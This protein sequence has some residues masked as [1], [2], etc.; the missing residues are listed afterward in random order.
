MKNNTKVEPWH[1]LINSFPDKSKYLEIVAA[2]IN[3]FGDAG[4]GYSFADWGRIVRQQL[5]NPNEVEVQSETNN[6]ELSLEQR[7]LQYLKNNPFSKASKIASFLDINK[8]KVNSFLY[9]L[10]I[11]G[12]CAVDSDYKWHICEGNKESTIEESTAKE[13]VVEEP[14][15]VEYVVEEP[16]SIKYTLKQD[17]EEYKQEIAEF[18]EALN[19]LH[20]SNREGKKAPHKPILL[21]AIFQ[22]IQR[23]ILKD[24]KFGLTKHIEQE[25]MKI[26]DK[27]I[28]EDYPFRPNFNAPFWYMQ[29]EPFWKLYYKN[30]TEINDVWNNK[31]LTTKKQR[32]SL[33]A[34]L[35]NSLFNMLQRESV[36]TELLQHLYNIVRTGV[37][38]EPI[39]TLV[40]ETKV[41]ENTTTDV[42][43]QKVV[44]SRR[45]V[46]KDYTNDIVDQNV[47][48][49]FV[50]I[51]ETVKSR[52]PSLFLKY[53][54]DYNKEVY[55]CLMSLLSDD[56]F[57]IEGKKVACKIHE[58]NIIKI[59]R[60]FINKKDWEGLSSSAKGRWASIEF[61]YENEIFYITNQI[62]GHDIEAKNNVRINDFA[63]FLYE[64]SNHKY[65]INFTESSSGR[66]SN[67]YIHELRQI[68]SINKVDSK[69]KQE[70]E[71]QIP[72][73]EDLTPEP[74]QRTRSPRKSIR[75]ITAEG[76]IIQKSD[77]TKTY[78]S[79]FE[80]NYP[81]LIVEIDFGDI[82]VISKERMPDFPNSVRYQKYLSKGYYVSTNFDTE[83]KAQILQKISDE[84]GLGYTIEVFV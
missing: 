38:G 47:E 80:D 63:I 58:S 8:S 27:E 1:L 7:I 2:C 52:V 24:N 42:E 10:K 32:S 43:K 45:I 33:I 72:F 35:D 67:N 57:T 62:D 25:F 18:K 49:S 46:S 39:S 31:I 70:Q 60:F 44:S 20:V 73:E 3:K 11:Q 21:I 55:S 12:T 77:A 9:Y 68:K 83:T 17:A 79:V 34:E 61:E 82:L 74:K 13:Y 36:F 5:D 64:G 26:W 84:L 78:L 81:D 29:S 22:L 40:Q 71:L 37:K 6:V 16:A 28:P 19:N 23:G 4:K 50:C 48:E 65:F 30:G 75:I 14:T 41:L 76:K 66:S 69:P 56:E 51:S 15:T 53:V 54:Y 59:K